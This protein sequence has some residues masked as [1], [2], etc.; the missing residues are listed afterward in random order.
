MLRAAINEGTGRAAMLSGPNFGKTGTSQDNRDALFVGYAGDY[1][2]G[3]WI[4]NDDN[5]PLKGV[6]GGGAPARIWKD[7]MRRASGRG[8]A[9]APRSAPTANPAGPVEPLDVPDLGD[10]PMGDSTRLRIEDGQATITTDLGGVPVD[11]RLD[12]RGFSINGD[13][14]AEEVERRRARQEERAA[15]REQRQAE[16]EAAQAEREA[17]REAARAGF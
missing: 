7:F 2:V 9:P 11:V 13:A 8:A 17:E 14:I 16:R 6:S 10:I 3:V 5:S 15:T 4:G 1:V 12:E